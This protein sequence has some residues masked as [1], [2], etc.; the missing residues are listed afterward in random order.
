MYPGLAILMGTVSLRLD[1]KQP[2]IQPYVSTL[3]FGGAF[4][5]LIAVA[6]LPAFLEDLQ[7]FSKEHANGLVGQYAFSVAKFFSG[8]PFLFL[9]VCI[10]SLVTYFLI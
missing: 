4:V 7:T 1:S 2:D 6:C 8:L 10:V 5:S 3:F 9:M